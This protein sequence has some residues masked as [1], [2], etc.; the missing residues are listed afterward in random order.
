MFSPNME[1][2]P[3]GGSMRAA[4]AP[5]FDIANEMT[6]PGFGPIGDDVGADSGFPYLALV[7]ELGHCSGSGMADP[8]T[9]AR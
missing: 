1:R 4:P 2:V 5:T 7:H 3:I 9:Q 6:D 8:T